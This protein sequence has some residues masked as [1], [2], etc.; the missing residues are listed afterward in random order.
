MAWVAGADV[1]TGDLITA[2][3]WN[4]YLGAGGDIDLLKIETDKIDDISQTI[5]GNADD[6]IYLN[7]THF[8]L[9][10]VSADLDADEKYQIFVE[11]ATPPTIQIGELSN[12]ATGDRITPSITFI[13]PPGWY[14]EVST[15]AGAPSIDTWVEWDLH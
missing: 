8:R 13:V 3:Q 12:G 14:Y 4:T 9:V 1:T 11:N 5:P 6:T 7:G 2:A 15:E 10:C